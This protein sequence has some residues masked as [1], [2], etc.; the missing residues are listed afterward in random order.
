[1]NEATLSVMKYNIIIMFY[2]FTSSYLIVVNLV[3]LQ[4]ISY[5]FLLFIIHIS[6]KHTF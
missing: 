5:S 4:F 3:Q 2:Q 6:H 1:M